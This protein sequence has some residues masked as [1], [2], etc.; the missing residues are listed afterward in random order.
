ML[1]QVLWALD[2]E[3][4]PQHFERLCTDL[5]GREGYRNII[6]VGGMHDRG[7]DAEIFIYTGIGKEGE[8]TFFQYSLEKT[9]ETKLKRELKK[10]KENGH[11][12]SRYI[13]V[14]TQAVTG[15]KR[16]QLA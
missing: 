1:S 2:N 13:F 9:W 4:D 14:T 3:I 8:V 7:R 16:D 15:N 11:S 10:V 6:P 5:M 12:I